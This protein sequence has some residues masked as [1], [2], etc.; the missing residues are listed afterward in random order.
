VRG[1]LPRLAPM[2]LMNCTVISSTAAM[3]M[4][5]LDSVVTIGLGI[6]NVNV[7]EDLPR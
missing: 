6:D 3:T 7:S 5:S 2:M 1:D 4:D